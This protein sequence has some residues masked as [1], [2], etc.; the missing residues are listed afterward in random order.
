MIWLLRSFTRQGRVESLLRHNHLF[1]LNWSK[2]WLHSS[3]SAPSACDQT[4]MFLHLINLQPLQNKV[5]NILT[6]FPLPTVL[7]VISQLYDKKLTDQVFLK[8]STSSSIIRKR[9]IQKLLM[10]KCDSARDSAK[11]TITCYNCGE[12]GHLNKECSTSRVTCGRCGKDEYF[13]ECCSDV[14][15]LLK[16]STGKTS[17]E[18]DTRWLWLALFLWLHYLTLFW[19]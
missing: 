11:R 12:I 10:P 15:D 3:W 1:F 16:R 6:T 18:R 17:R 9:L 7:E 8:T 5:R 4:T 2:P 13:D 14:S 19:R